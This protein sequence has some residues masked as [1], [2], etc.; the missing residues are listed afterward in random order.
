MKKVGSWL[1]GLV[2]VVIG[3]ILGLNA[4]GLTNIN[5][6]F[7]GWWTLI[8]IV[9]CA[10]NLFTDDHKWG[11]L[12]GLLIGVCLLLGCLDV[13]SFEMVWKL[14]FPV[15]LILVGVAVIFRGTARG[16]IAKK[17]REVR[18][19]QG[20]IE[21]QEYWATFGEQDVTYD[22]KVFQG[23]RLDAVFGGIDLDLR[24]AK[25][26][27]DAIVRASSIF[28]GITIYVPEH[29]KVEVISTP[30]FGGVNDERPKEKRAENI[31]EGEVVGE[32]EKAHTKKAGDLKTLYIDA[33]CVF[34]GVEIK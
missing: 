23:C 10:I 9:P 25:L 22:G 15:V 16:A 17:L 26:K 27:E 21:T 19:G 7:P 3:V 13:L 2:L 30:I 4:L 29:V 1:W 33:T 5:I 34:G 32:S 14:F 28:G 6:F 18:N 24:G 20:E 11:N 8:I 31:A 12:I